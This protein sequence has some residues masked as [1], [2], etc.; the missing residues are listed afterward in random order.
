MCSCLCFLYLYLFICRISSFNA[1]LFIIVHQFYF[2]SSLYSPSLSF[3]CL[4]CFRIFVS[5]FV[6]PGLSCSLLYS[7]QANWILFM[8]PQ[9]LVFVKDLQFPLSII[10]LWFLD[11]SNFPLVI[12][13]SAALPSS[14][15]LAPYLCFTKRHRAWARHCT[16]PDSRMRGN[17]RAN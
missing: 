10:L 2:S 5:L 14:H 16:W 1:F 17:M 11:L 3:L 13:L 12:V 6:N 4:F 9:C 8:C 7:P 15:C